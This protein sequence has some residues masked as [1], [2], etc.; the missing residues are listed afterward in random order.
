LPLPMWALLQQ[1]QQLLALRARRLVP[2][3][4]THFA[5][6]TGLYMILDLS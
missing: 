1:K 6:S 4:V 5:T 2:V 3:V